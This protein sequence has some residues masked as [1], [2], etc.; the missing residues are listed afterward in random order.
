MSRG[1]PAN[2]SS[3]R[4]RMYHSDLV[5]GVFHGRVFDLFEEA[6]TEAFRRLGF[7]YREVDEAGQAMVVTAISARF[8]AA[9]QMDGL[10]QVGVYVDALRKAQVL[11]G[12]EGRRAQDGALLFTGETNFA[13]V[14]KATGRPVRVPAGIHRALER[15]PGMLRKG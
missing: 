8:H 11:I 9:G 15:C 4:L 7:E 10:V 13:F 12:Y 14:D 5:N 1:L 2:V 6:R 3:V